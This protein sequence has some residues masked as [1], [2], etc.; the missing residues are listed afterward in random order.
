MSYESSEKY[1]TLQNLFG[2][3]ELK[4]KVDVF[5]QLGKKKTTNNLWAETFLL[6]HIF[7]ASFETCKKKQRAT[8]NG[9]SDIFLKYRNSK[10]ADRGLYHL[11]MRFSLFALGVNV[12][13]W[14]YR[15]N[16]A[17]NDRSK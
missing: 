10:V 13:I 1:L 12:I 5:S 8:L 15:R 6:E 16:S 4:K 17:F 2:T 7:K 11:G 14:R 3:Q 9:S